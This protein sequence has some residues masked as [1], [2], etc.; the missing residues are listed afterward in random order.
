MV[1]GIGDNIVS[2]IKII[3]VVVCLGG[4]GLGFALSHGFSSCGSSDEETAPAVQGEPAPM[5]TDGTVYTYILSYDCP[6]SRVAGFIRVPEVPSAEKDS[7]GP[8]QGVFYSMHASC[9]EACE[10][11]K[12][13]HKSKPPSFVRVS[14]GTCEIK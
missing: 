7:G 2:G 8:A 4:I 11:W 10:R 12:S 1:Q 13:E 14:E 6:E 9:Q 5:A 3:I